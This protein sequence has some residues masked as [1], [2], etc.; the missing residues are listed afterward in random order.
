[1]KLKSQLI[2]PQ[3][4]CYPNQT[5][6]QYGQMNIVNNIN[7]N[8]W[9]VKQYKQYPQLYQMLWTNW[10]N[11]TIIKLLPKKCWKEMNQLCYTRSTNY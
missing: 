1:M 6:L 2:N 7:S 3:F 8:E 4:R 10:I 11:G 9:A 5:R